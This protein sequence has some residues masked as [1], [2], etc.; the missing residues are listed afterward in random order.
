M[1]K[2]LKS[3]VRS[4][5]FDAAAGASRIVRKAVMMCF[6]WPTTSKPR[7]PALE[8]KNYI[9]VG[10]SMGGKVAS[11]LLPGNLRD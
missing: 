3:K 5:A 7:S 9:L 4:V 6:P 11:F 8:L 10:H 2:A 1:I